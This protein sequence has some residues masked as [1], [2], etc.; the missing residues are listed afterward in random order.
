MPL[1]DQIYCLHHLNGNI[2]QHLHPAL[3]GDWQQFSSEFWEVYCAV[4]PHE[5][6]AKWERL[7]QHFPTPSVVRYLKDKIYPCRDWWAWAWI[8][9]RF[10]AG[11]CTTGWPEVENR[12][13]KFLSGPK[14][15]FFQVFKVFVEHSEQQ[16]EN[17][18]IDIVNV[19]RQYAGLFAFQK[20]WVKMDKSLLYE[21]DVLQR[22]PGAE[23]FY[24][25]NQFKNSSAYIPTSHLL[26][27]CVARR[28]QVTHLLRIAHL[29][30][31]GSSH[32][33]AVLSDG[34]V[35]C[36]CCM[37]INLGIPCRHFFAAWLKFPGLGFHISI[38]RPR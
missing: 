25:L 17:V 6:D 21:I 36:D 34:R 27:L 4:S 9:T 29:S 1:T 26:H 23:S 16:I 14:K 15:T 38:I 31:A 28:L 20:C 30:W 19:L 24:M 22:P 33:P 11:I 32:I 35:I 13:T 8:S 10:T 37:N 2:A 5:F 18:F 3:G 12:I 7:L